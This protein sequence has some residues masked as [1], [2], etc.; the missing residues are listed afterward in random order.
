[1]TMRKKLLITIA[2]LSCILCI[3][4]TGTIA[5]LIDDTPTITNTFTPSNIE[6]DLTETA[7]VFKMIPGTAIEKDPKVTVDTDIPC[8]VFVK[9]EENLGAWSTFASG[10]KNFK[11]FLEYSIADGWTAVPGKT[12]VYYFVAAGDS[13]KNVLAGNTEYPNGVITVSGA[14]V[15]KKMMDA[16][17]D[18][19]G[20]VIDN[21]PKLQFTAYAIQSD[22]LAYGDAVTEDEKAMVAWEAINTPATT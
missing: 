18:Q 1:M 2:C 10:E 17:Y 19:N 9:V 16:L 11:T 7:D 21:L 14:N 22:Y 15:T 20:E 13:S 4:V 6:V 3:M 8:Y 12:G 5:W